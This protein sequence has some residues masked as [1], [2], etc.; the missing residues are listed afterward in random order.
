M[1]NPSMFELQQKLAEKMAQDRQQV[2]ALT[3]S[4]LNTHAE[5]LTQ[6]SSAALNTTLNAIENHLNQRLTQIQHEIE[7][8]TQPLSQTLNQLQQQAQSLNHLTVRSWLKPLLIGLSLLLGIFA[9]SWGLTAYFSHQITQQIQQQ[10]QLTQQIDAQQHTLNQ[11]QAK[12]WGIRYLQND[13]GRYL[14]LPPGTTAS[15]GWMVG[16][17]QAIKL[18]NNSNKP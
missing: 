2:E 14:I 4:A 18:G 12:T 8:Q 9:G 5:H 7:Q 17:Q 15:T 10:A 1:P 6:Q 11:I 13:Q 3:Q 16:T